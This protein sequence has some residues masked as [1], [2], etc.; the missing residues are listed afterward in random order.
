MSNK[1][2]WASEIARKLL[3]VPL[4]RRWAH[5][6]GVARQARSLAPILGSDADLLEAAA[7]LHDIG[8]S[9]EIAVTGFHP[10]DGARY[11]RDVQ[12]AEDLLCRLVAGHSCA[13]IEAEQR[14]L[15]E[16]LA[17]EFPPVDQVLSDALSY[18]DMTTTPDGT[19]TVVTHRLS[20]IQERYGPDHLVSHFVQLAEPHLIGAVRNTQERARRPKI[21]VH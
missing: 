15:A 8:Y 3:E 14:G 17:V 19:A 4:P 12:R 21:A 6:Q 18:C 7:W 5:T 13:H 20:E 11:L 2:A 1:A 9:P 16:Q 10:L